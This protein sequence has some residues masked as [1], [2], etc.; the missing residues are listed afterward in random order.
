MKNT[1]ATYRYA[2]ALLDLSKEQGSLESCKDDMQT[3]MSVCKGSRELVLL[4]KS[5]VIKTDKKLAIL[6]EVFANCSELSLSFITIIAKKKRE[7][8]LAD[9][10]EKFLA[11]YQKNLGIE[12]V[13][14]TTASPIQED[15]REKIIA[16]VHQQGV[17]S[18]E[19]V[20]QVDQN[21]IGGLI[22]RLGDQ[23]L[24][25]SIKTQINDLKQSFSKNLYIKDF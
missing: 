15:T 18:I 21:L 11:I 8:L 4:L 23:Q 16:F 3:I 7:A 24:D 14:L 9:I 20:E 17:K 13:R 22:L 2:K 19:L 12:K 5:P 1:R 10:A 25:A 6:K